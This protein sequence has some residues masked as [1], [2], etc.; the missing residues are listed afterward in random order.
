MGTHVL[1]LPG[2]HDL[3]LWV[4][5]IGDASGPVLVFVIRGTGGSPEFTHLVSRVRDQAEVEVLALAEGLLRGDGVVGDPDYLGAGLVE[6]WGSIT[7]PLAFECS[8]GGVGHRVPPEDGPLAAEISVA[9]RLAV[10]V[11]DR[12]LG[13]SVAGGE[14][15]LD[16]YTHGYG[17]RQ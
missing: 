14:H 9:E 13:Y 7:E 3:R 17:Q 4:D 2:A 6:L 8:A 10:L 1:D 11:D 12:E 5:E 16:S 15:K